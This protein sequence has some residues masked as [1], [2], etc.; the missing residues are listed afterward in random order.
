[1]RFLELQVD[2]FG[3]LKNL[4][5]EMHS[6][7][8][9]VVGHNEAGKSSFH[10]ALET[11]LYGFEVSSREK[12]PL[13]QFRSGDDLEVRAKVQLDDQST[14]S[15]RRVL[16]TQGKL[17]ILDSD[18]QVQRSSS[19]NEPL[20][21]MQ[22]VPRSLFRAVYS[23]T[24]NDTDMQKDDVRVHIREL[25]LGETGLRG[26]R[27]ISTVRS[28]V[29]RDMQALWRADLRGTPLAKDLGKKLK[30]AK[31]D[32]RAAK[33]IDRELREAKREL[34]RLRL[35]RNTDQAHLVELRTQLEELSF[36]REWRVYRAK[37]ASV[38]LIDTRL[39][40]AP[41]EWNPEALSNPA[42]LEKKQES[43]AKQLVGP[44]DRLTRPTKA[45]P[46]HQALCLEREA[47]IETVLGQ[48]SDRKDLL[49]TQ[50]LA[51][52][53]LL[54][55]TRALDEG[56]HRL[57]LGNDASKTLGAFPVGTLQADADHWDADLEQFE[58]N[59]MEQ[60]ASP[61][62]I[63]GVV[64][65]VA[66][67]VA[68][69]VD[70]GPSWAG[71]G[72]TLLGFGLAIGCFLRPTRPSHDDP[73]PELPA[74]SGELLKSLGLHDESP[75]TPQLLSRIADQLAEGQK[76]LSEARK[77]LQT[78]K[79]ALVKLEA[80]E[81]EWTQLAKTLG[82]ASASME[83]LPSELRQALKRAEQTKQD[84]KEDAH[85]REIATGLCMVLQPQWDACEQKIHITRALLTT[86]F[87]DLADLNQAFAAWS[88]LGRKRTSAE[89]DWVRL[90]ASPY[91][92]S[93]HDIPTSDEASLGHSDPQEL[94]L[95]IEA[96]EETSKA[97]SVR[98]GA[99]E[100]RLASDRT[101]H[102]ARA[103]ERVIELE[104]RLQ[105]TR[106]NRDQLALLGRVLQTAEARYR[107]KNEPDV[108]SKAGEYLRE[109]SQGRY[110]AL[111]YPAGEDEN[112]N[113]SCLQVLSV[114]D[115]LRDVAKPLSRGTQEQVYL[116]L[117][118]GTLDYLDE[119]REKLPLVL[120]EALVHW[121]HDRRDSLY[122]V[123]KKVAKKR[124][125]ILF[126]CH[127]SFA[128]EVE[129]AMG[130]RLIQLPNRMERQE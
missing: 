92:R 118:L 35:D 85:E 68:Q 52:Q 78:K 84:V 93:G 53:G 127:Q 116:A 36:H 59:S 82:T 117:R 95:D 110:T 10:A 31:K 97:Q 58:L 103:E 91:Y 43:I 129:E 63:L 27:P 1:V 26:A 128:T 121:D 108:L 120:D 47:A 87:P 46:E 48:I 15:V 90:Q 94:R 75:R 11:I 105:D 54:E 64:V 114:E 14:L 5:C 55:S 50:T 60:E 72:A 40:N 71:L 125:V 8:F 100:E 29:E 32:K 24:A 38:D 7:V 80:L 18:G 70:L 66:G 107:E 112:P 33:E 113:E 61:Y 115:G 57:G 109:I 102:F 119:G 30:Q 19:N 83:A 42:E 81:S 9:V 130:A 45:I 69:G 86:A 65:G 123:L 111:V 104:A 96:L 98:L 56:L 67:V 20:P 4:Q 101:A 99:L 76:H 34:E 3:P 126:T 2:N 44:R 79:G 23:L 6:D 28:E 22:S 39:V 106:E 12:H 37:Q 73:R 21:V 16:M 124:Q 74:S 122:T 17:E 51:H 62:W 49:R 77:H 13:A 41:Q 88:E 25:L 89:D